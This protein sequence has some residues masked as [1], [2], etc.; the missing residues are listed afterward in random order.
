MID[1]R[2]LL[3]LSER[4]ARGTCEAD[5]RAAVSRAYYSA[6]HHAREFFQALGFDVPRSDAAHAFFWRR[7]ENSGH[8]ALKSA[9]STLVQLRRQRNR[10][11][12]DVHETVIQRDARSVI[13]RAAE[14]IHLI[15]S[16]GSG[17]RQ[18]AIEV[19]RT[20]ER[21]VLRETTWRVRPR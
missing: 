6:F 21:D 18:A 20:Y 10:A 14:T 5:W 17:D 4:L 9:G 11:D 12:Y 15:D 2:E 19:I 3:L 16:L 1:S 13:T 7:M 8:A